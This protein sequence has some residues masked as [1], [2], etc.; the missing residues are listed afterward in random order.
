MYDTDAATIHR[1]ISAEFTIQWTILIMA[2]LQ[3][4]VGPG[5]A[6]AS[7]WGYKYFCCAGCEI[8]FRNFIP[9]LKPRYIC[10]VPF[11][12]CWIL[13]LDCFRYFMVSYF[14]I[15]NLY[16]HKFKFI[17]M[18][19]RLISICQ[20]FSIHV[21]DFRNSCSIIC[22]NNIYHWH[23]AF[24]QPYPHLYSEKIFIFRTFSPNT[25]RLKSALVFCFFCVSNSVLSQHRLYN[26]ND[27]CIP[28]EGMH[29]AGSWP[30]RRWL[31]FNSHQSV[32]GF[33]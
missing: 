20:Q 32:E 9:E 23:S 6:P 14:K 22:T 29:G 18:R 3:H 13:R 7:D 30:G 12:C 2:R 25:L 10:A 27:H 5:P 1:Y 16:D 17:N 4:N 15:I 31:E 26:H 21:M 11:M 28:I 8:F 19:L 33:Q 24:R